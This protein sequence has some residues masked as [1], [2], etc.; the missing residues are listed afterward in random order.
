MNPNTYT[1]RKYDSSRRKFLALETRKL[2]TESARI[3]FIERGYAGTT[4]ESIAQASA[5]STETVYAIF[6]K[7]RNILSHLLDIAVG[8]DELSVRLLDR[9]DPQGVL[10]EVDPSNQV[11]LFSQGITEILFRAAP[12][13]EILRSAA[14]SDDEIAEL[15]KNRLK[16]RMEN[17][18]VFVQHIDK[19]HGLRDG[20]N[21]QSAADLVWTI[22][23]PE[24][25]LLLTR[26]Q[27][28]S[29]EQFAN[30]LESTL[31]RLLIS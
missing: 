9:P 18:K 8:G 5:V 23:S 6:Q 26:D 31:G 7:K 12:V 14:K 22:T 11:K 2:I 17:M 15:V 3:L 4:I 27:N 30:W 21:V 16:G 19:N 1:K 25:F 20:L 28:Y 29:V 24:V 10:H 13:F